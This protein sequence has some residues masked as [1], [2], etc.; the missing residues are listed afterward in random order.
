MS[1]GYSVVFRQRDGAVVR[2]STDVQVG[3][4]LG[5]KLAVN[6]AKTLGGCEEVEATV[7]GVKGPVDC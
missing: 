5:I 4:R 2:T 6:G 3:E 7:T 1:R